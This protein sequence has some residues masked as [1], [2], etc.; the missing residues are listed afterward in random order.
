MNTRKFKALFLM[1]AIAALTISCK[2]DP[3]PEPAPPATDRVIITNAGQQANST[4]SISFYNPREKSVSHNIFFKNNTYVPGDNLY[5]I[6]VDGDRS[7]LVMAGTGEILEV[8]TK[9]M[10]MRERYEGFGAP[11]RMLK[12]SENRF[13]VSDWQE[14][15][16]WIL[17]TNNGNLIKSIPTGIGP[18]NMV[19]WKDFVFVANSGAAFGDSSVTMIHALADTV[20]TQ[21]RVGRN[22]QLYANRQRQ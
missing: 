20:M 7:F 1:A 15:G 19:K 12:I 3:Q 11:H 18:E 9:T 14:Q 13:Y 6:Y 4:G 10:K 2:E 5:S 8:D 16:V 21:I 17:N 22:P